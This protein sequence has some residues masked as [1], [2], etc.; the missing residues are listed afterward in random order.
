M[1][2]GHFKHLPQTQMGVR[3]W[4]FMHRLRLWLGFEL[5]TNKV[6]HLTQTH[7]GVGVG[8]LQ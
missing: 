8:V 1:G 2:R 3:V 5:H 7:V 6:V 4:Y